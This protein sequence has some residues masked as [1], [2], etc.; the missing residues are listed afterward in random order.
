MYKLQDVK[1]QVASFCGDSGMCPDDERVI[2]RINE[3]RRILYPLGDWKGTTD[4]ICIKPC[5]CYLSLPATYEYAKTGYLCKRKVQIQNDWFVPINMED[6][7]YY[8]GPEMG[9]MIQQPGRYVTFQDWFSNRDCTCNPNGFFIKVVLES[10]A[11]KGVEL[12]FKGYGAQ[13]REVSLTRIVD[14]DSHVPHEAQAGEKR[15]LN[16]FYVSKPRTHGRIRIYGYD[17]TN[18]RL[19]AIYDPEDVDP[20]YVRYNARGHSRNVVL[21]AKKRFRD[22]PDKDYTLVDIHPDALIHCLQGIADRQA[23]NIN[24][25]TANVSLAVAFL[26]RELQGPE[27]TTTSPIQMSEAYKV[28]GLIC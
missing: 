10:H 1:R 16:L 13:Q 7:S 2:E 5:S 26:N 21:K 11:D 23:K 27:S 12:H 4:A 18:E 15:M 9:R 6:F 22:L 3:A 25:M 24:G 14:V 19:L 17:G 8:C 20:E 28:T